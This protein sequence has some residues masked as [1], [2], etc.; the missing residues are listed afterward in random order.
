M[1]S[2]NEIDLK[3]YVGRVL[4]RLRHDSGLSQERLAEMAGLERGYIS[5]IERGLRMPTV[6]TVFRLSRGMKTAP[7]HFV[8]L[9]EEELK[10]G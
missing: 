2:P 6:D 4:A 1:A 7:S 8:V 5:L 3:P 9:V 10:K